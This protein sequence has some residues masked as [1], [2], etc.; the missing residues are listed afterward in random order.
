VQLFWVTDT[1]AVITRPRWGDG[2]NADLAGL[3]ARGIDVLASCLTS[4]EETELGLAD[5][6]AAARAAGLAFVRTTIT[7]HSVPDGDSVDAAIEALRR[8]RNEG[9]RVAVHC[10]AGLG[11]SPLIAAALLIADGVPAAAAII[12]VTNARGV[13]V[14]ETQEQRAWLLAR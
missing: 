1:L 3:R 6:E 9:R 12:R 8:A 13:A 4:Y 7:D 2:L 11:R 10:R 5:E 14:P